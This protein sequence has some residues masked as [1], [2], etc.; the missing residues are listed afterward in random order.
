MV[1]FKRKLYRRGS[2]METTV[3]KPLLFALDQ[4]KR[5]NVLFKFDTSS[6]RWYVEFEEAEEKESGKKKR[7]KKRRTKKK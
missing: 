2:S 5:H 7:A 3:P 1:E 6:N 4:E